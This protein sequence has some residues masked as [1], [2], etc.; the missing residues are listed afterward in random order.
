MNRYTIILILIVLGVL[1][2]WAIRS[3]PKNGVKPVAEA[4]ATSTGQDQIRLSNMAGSD[5][6][7]ILLD[8]RR[9]SCG[10]D[11]ILRGTGSIEVE[12]VLSPNATC[13]SR[14]AVLV[15]DNAMYFDQDFSAWTDNSGDSLEVGLSPMPRLPI[16]IWVPTG[17][18]GDAK[19][20]AVAAAEIFNDM[21][22]GIGFEDS[23]PIT[24]AGALDS[25]GANC[26][27]LQPLKNIGEG[28]GLNVYYVQDITDADDARG[29]LCST[30]PKVIL[31]S[32]PIGVTAT[33]AHEIGHALKLE[34]TN[35]VDGLNTY[36]ETEPGVA[37]CNLMLQSGVNQ[38]LLSTGQSFRANMNGESAINTLHVRTGPTLNC[39]PVNRTPECP[40][41]AFDVVPK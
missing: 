7:T 23:V 38:K 8:G 22:S 18:T 26:L 11:Q 14:I 10:D 1:L 41:L 17:G 13:R 30:D 29:I 31:I 34:H 3:C 21:Q 28:P 15:Q 40:E 25:M 36:V 9:N 35:D 39:D 37:I 24:E 27:N 33:L 32:V 5:S 4:T 6:A 20:H 2:A 19:T 16:S 12:N